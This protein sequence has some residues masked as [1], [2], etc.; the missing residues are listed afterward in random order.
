ML[1][2]GEASSFL[3]FLQY[4]DDKDSIFARFSRKFKIGLFQDIVKMSFNS[5]RA[6]KLRATLTIIVIAI[7]IMALVGI[8]TAIESIKTTITEQFTFMGANSFLIQSRS[9]NVQIGNS[10]YRKKNYSYISYREAQ[11]F[12]DSYDFPAYVSISTWATGIATAKFESIKTDPNIRVRGVDENY[13]ITTGNE[14]GKG[15]NFSVQDIL[16]NRNFAIIGKGLARTLFEEHQDPIGKIISVGPGKFRVIGVLADKGSSISNTDRECLVPVSQVRSHFPSPNRNHS[17]QVMPYDPK[18]L[19]YASSEAEGVFRI[20]RGL[21]ARDETDFNITKS[22]QIVAM[23]I[24]NLKYVTIAATVIGLITLLGAVVG[25]MN[26]MLVSVTERTR[27]IGIRKAIGSRADTIKKQFLFE[28]ILIGQIG[29]FFGIVLG[30]LVGNVVSLLTKS[31]FIIPWMWIFGGV[32]ATF[33]VGLASGYF[34]AVKASKLDP[35]IALHY[36]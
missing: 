21:D 30:I 34:P 8:L 22:D 25:L 14:L 17:M 7:G 31:S 16:M 33:L 15:R 1:V 29:G 10:K 4:M 19:D 9:I 12:K 13:L 2:M 35:I 23:L 3:I 26:I 18:N 36:E 5:I 27:E 11:E 20:V 28:A 32:A 24:E 6:S